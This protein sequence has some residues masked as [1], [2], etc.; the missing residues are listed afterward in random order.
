LDENPA[1]KLDRVNETPKA[2]TRWRFGLPASSLLNI[3]KT[4]Q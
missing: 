4:A 2:I 3:E 1:E